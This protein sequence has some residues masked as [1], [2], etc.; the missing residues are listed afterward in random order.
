MNSKDR[1]VALAISI[2]AIKQAS[3]DNEHK[4]KS[5]SKPQNKDI[6]TMTVE[7]KIKYYKR[8]SRHA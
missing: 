1:T 8:K 5:P 6:T 3:I 4:A 2:Q 7:E